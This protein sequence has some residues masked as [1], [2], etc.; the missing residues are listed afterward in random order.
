MLSE[1]AYLRTLPMMTFAPG[2]AIMIT[3]L[4]INFIRCIAGR[5]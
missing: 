2:L 1:R 4:A 5:L 3:V